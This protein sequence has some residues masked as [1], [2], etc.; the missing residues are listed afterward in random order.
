[1]KISVSSSKKTK[2]N[3]EQQIHKH[4]QE[5]TNRN[6]KCMEGVMIGVW[7]R[8]VE[9]REKNVYFYLFKAEFLH[10]AKS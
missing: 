6:N 8:T 2:K 9:K 10:K 5:Q 4:P 7:R 3:T 1:M